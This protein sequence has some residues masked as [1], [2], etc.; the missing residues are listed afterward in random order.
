MSSSEPPSRIPPRNQTPDTKAA[1]DEFSSKGKVEKVREVDADETRKK[2]QKFMSEE[3]VEEEDVKPSPFDLYSNKAV[4]PRQPAD[5]DDLGDVDDAIVASPSYSPPPDVKSVPVVK[6]DEEGMEDDATTQALPQSDDFW[7]EV[8]LPPDQPRPQVPMKPMKKPD[9]KK[10]DSPFG[11]P[12]KPTLAKKGEA[13]P[14]KKT[15]GEKGKEEYIEAQVYVPREEREGGRGG[16]RERKE[17]MVLTEI[18]ELPKFSPSIQPVAV[19]A[20]VQATSYISPSTIPLFFQMVGTMYV[21]TGP[22]GVTQT[23]FILNNPSYANSKFFGATITI[24]KYA[25]APDSFNIRLTGSNEAVSTFRNQIPSL[26]NAFENGNYNFR[27]NRIDVEYK[28]DRP[29][30]R[31]KEGRKD[32]GGGDLGERR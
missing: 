32:T 9:L 14:P 30:Y 15:Q 18:A 31:R 29:V 23:E 10:G 21:M 8:D 19:S 4:A 2:F 20:T 27:V 17:K 6:G 1:R 3:P 11:P 25:T 13:P 24:E 7:D 26:L 5:T 22:R 28:V 12:G 16:E